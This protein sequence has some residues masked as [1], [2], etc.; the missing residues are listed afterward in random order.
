MRFVWLM[1]TPFVACNGPNGSP[2]GND[3][4][5]PTDPPPAELCEAHPGEAVCDGQTAVQCADDG[6]MDSFVGC[7]AACVDGVCVTCVP[8]LDVPYS[9]GIADGIT[10]E[11]DTSGGPVAERFPRMRP[12]VV[13]G[14]PSVSWSGP[15]A[16]YSVDGTPVVSGDAVANDTLLIGATAVGD[17]E[18]TLTPADG[19]DAERIQL[20][21]L[22]VEPAPIAVRALDGFPWAERYDVFTSR[23]TVSGWVDGS[24]YPD[25]VGLAADL[26]VVP[27]RTPADW[28][29]DPSLDDAVAGPAAATIGNGVDPVDVWSGIFSST[30]PLAPYDLVVDFGQDGRLDPGDLLDGLDA[31]AF[32]VGG[33]LAFPGPYTPV[34]TR[35]SLSFWITSRVYYPEELDSLDPMPLVVISHGNGH[36]YTWY[37]YLGNHFA[38]YGYVVI[39]HRN[40]TEPGPVTA[41]ETTWENTDAFLSNLGNLD[42]GVLD[43]EVDTH[44]IA[45]IGHSRGGEGVVIAYDDLFEGSI[46]PSTFGT[47][48]V[49]LVSSIAPTVFQD[50]ERV[51]NPHGVLYHLMAGSLD[52]DVTGGVDSDITQYLRIFQNS[53]GLNAVSYVQGADHNDFNCCGDNDANWGAGGPGVEIGRNRAQQ[54][55]KS[56]Y[57]ALLEATFHGQSPYWEYL[58]RAP[59][60]FRPDGTEVV[61]SSQLKRATDKFVI[62]DFQTSPDPAVSS[63]GGAVTGTVHDLAEGV[64]DD[65]D[66]QLSNDPGDPMNGM[67]QSQND[68][69]P[70]RGVVFEWDDGD[71]LTLE[72]EIPASERDLTDDGFVSFRACQGTRHPNTLALAGMASFS[73]ALVDSA[74]NES[75]I[76]YRV[77]GGVPSPYRRN[78]LGNGTGWINE[79]QSIRIPIDA[80]AWDGRTIDLTDVV[81]VRFL[82]GANHGSSVGRIGLDDLEI[83]APS[84]PGVP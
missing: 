28:A 27:H 19:C 56:Y 72:F 4:P 16:V 5:T 40:N 54:L 61:V 46:S 14:T 35:L 41:A 9:A 17:G 73:V 74:G 39:S 31:P 24:R 33:D 29:A 7:D 15:F 8:S 75:A 43:G 1:W 82:F 26:Y 20:P 22:A 57:L 81:A 45:W 60:L 12:L 23:D 44:A 49:K 18:L 69:N 2:D 34:V 47:D 50:P 65:G 13:T 51:V 42:G 84:A 78:G 11:V 6:T 79:F 38:S 58:T 67:S 52:G 37:D 36:D 10:V 66:S 55:A 3:D 83:L 64:M 53:T 63:S 30:P 71:D 48:D 76:D 32:V 77:Y 21:L 59:E 80:F 68:A 70:A 62:D 25:R